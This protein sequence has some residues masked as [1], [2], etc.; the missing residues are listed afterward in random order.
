M[1]YKGYTDLRYRHSKSRVISQRF[2]RSKRASASPDFLRTSSTLLYV[3]YYS[4]RNAMGDAT[5]RTEATNTTVTTCAVQV[6]SN[7]P[8]VA[9][10]TMV[11]HAYPTRTTVIGY[12]IVRTPVMRRRVFTHVRIPRNSCARRG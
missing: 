9:T 10:S 1:F 7:V 12:K 11:I 3:D 5:A 2:V 4:F 6:N 8:T